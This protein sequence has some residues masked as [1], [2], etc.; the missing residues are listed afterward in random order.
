MR[1][2]YLSNRQFK[3][4]HLHCDFELSIITS[5][6]A[7]FTAIEVHG[8]YFHFSQC[9]FRKV[10]SLGLMKMHDKNSN[11]KRL[12]KRCV[13]LPLMPIQE[14]DQC[15]FMINLDNENYNDD[16]V[17]D[18]LI[19]IEKTWLDESATFPRKIWNHHA[20]FNTRTTNHVEG[21]H[22]KLNRCF[23]TNSVSVF[24]LINQLKRFEIN[25]RADLCRAERGE[26][27]H[28]K[29]NKYVKLNESYIFH[30]ISYQLNTIDLLDY[31]D[32]C[33]NLM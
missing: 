19:Y 27:I 16:I 7:I 13:A 12:F 9:L 31:I 23:T 29:N 5:F 6:K 17:G 33:T 21:F 30:T 22:N 28:Q 2:A 26:S 3:P 25:Y 24:C 18:F 20:N 15:W 11:F 8:C 4:K 32:L 10:Q 1:Q 14:I